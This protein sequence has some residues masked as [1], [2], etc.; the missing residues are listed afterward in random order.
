MFAALIDY[1][2]VSEHKELSNKW[3]RIYIP[4]GYKLPFSIKIIQFS[5][6]SLNFLIFIKN[7]FSTKYICKLNKN[8]LTKFLNC[9]PPM[10]DILQFSNTN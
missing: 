1:M 6:F 5:L 2:F 10:D 7:L 3:M 9:P 8:Y 4:N